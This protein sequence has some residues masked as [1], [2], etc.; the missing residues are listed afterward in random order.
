MRNYY[1]VTVALL[2]G[3]V[4]C[5]VHSDSNSQR[6]TDQVVSAVV[7][8]TSTDS[9][10]G[11]AVLFS[12]GQ[13]PV[14]MQTGNA[15]VR[16]PVSAPPTAPT[17][18]PT[19]PQTFDTA[20]QAASASLDMLAS[21]VGLDRSTKRGFGSPAEVRSSTLADG[22]PLQ[23][24]GLGKL[25]QF[26]PG[27]DTK[28]LSFDTQEVMYSIGV[29]GE[30]RSSVTVQKG[31]DGRWQAVKFGHAS[32]ARNAQSVR[33]DV[34]A[35]RS[36]D[37]GTLSLIQIPTVQAYLLS[38][39]EKGVHMV[40]PLWDIPGTSYTAGVTQPAAQVFAALQPLAARVDPT[41]SF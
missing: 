10:T 4:G 25:T 19:P 5:S 9:T 39:S 28:T 15:S 2:L 41:P 26:T 23:F 35:K 34:T 18:T 32:M 17:P 3:V 27:Q 31:A 20:A 33:S 36:I 37:P 7:A 21:V 40:T 6:G 38:H 22:L 16:S 29:G 8:S 11:G 1:S 13:A 30:V 12:A 14:P 24:V